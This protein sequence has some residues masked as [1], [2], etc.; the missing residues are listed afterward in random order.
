MSRFQPRSRPMQM[1]RSSVG[2][3]TL[4][5]L[6]SGAASA[7]A[8]GLGHLSIPL[9]AGAAAV[10]AGLAYLVG[11]GRRA[12]ALDSADLRHKTV[13]VTGANT[14]IGLETCKALISVGAH[15]IMVCRTAQR[16]VLAKETVVAAAR[17]G[18]SA[19]LVVMD[20]ADLA[21]VQAAVET[22]SDLGV[23]IS[24]L[25]NNAGI[26]MCP[27]GTTVQGH[28]T[29]WGV[30]HLGHMW[31]TLGLLDNISQAGGRIVNVA[32][33]AHGFD[34]TPLPITSA[35]DYDRVRAYG[36]SKIANILFTR[37]LNA[38]LV[39]ANSAARAYSLH[40]GA[41]N[42]ELLRH[43]TVLAAVTAPLRA[44]VF[45]NTWQGAQTS[46][47]CALDDDAEPGEYHAECRPAPTTAAA[48]D[49]DAAAALWAYSLTAA[50]S[51]R[52]PMP[53]PDAIEL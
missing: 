2:Q 21:S 23:S 28:E 36:R 25:I 50:E 12:T 40:P 46:L 17:L 53:D 32:S 18:G 44:I 51:S 6:T 10:G 8:W 29:Q 48:L 26:M 5:L 20:L 22:I 14:G 34:S 52:F 1:L 15:V 7:A 38:K 31:F 11:R 3:S 39:S 43:N 37:L 49:M 35:A 4:M 13:V 30:N 16:G 27:W 42:S 9:A 41:V 24:I 45:Q 47:Y 33:S 19:E